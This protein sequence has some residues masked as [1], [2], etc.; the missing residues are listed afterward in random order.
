M[1]DD[2]PRPDSKVAR[3]IDDYDLDGWG[4]TLER[5]WTGDVGERTSLRDLADI[6]NEEIMAAAIRDADMSVTAPD[7]TNT[8][9]ILAG[10][11]DVSRADRHR[12]EREL[13][14]AGVDVDSVRSDFVTH[15]AVHTY[16]TSYREVELEDHS[17]DRRQRAIESLQRLRGRTGAVTE[18]TIER[19]VATD[20][21][22][23]HEYE[24]FVDIK[25]VCQDCE[26]TF[27]VNELF[28]TGGCGCGD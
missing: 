25:V 2:D 6:L 19:M 9:R 12:K 15:Q 10:D 3:V 16:L 21:I 20:E 5:R 18:S 27:S 24:I 17:E 22:T 23:D 11:A 26:E 28:R 13:E 7:A 4:E 8:Y 14:Q 1:S